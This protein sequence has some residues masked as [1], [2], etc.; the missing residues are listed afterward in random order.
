MFL[1]GETNDEAVYASGAVVHGN[2]A[3]RVSLTS[4]ATTGKLRG[5]EADIK[6]DE[7]KFMVRRC[8][9]N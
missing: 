7:C 4:L 5:G 8:Y 9:G 2:V 1:H 3:G 6:E